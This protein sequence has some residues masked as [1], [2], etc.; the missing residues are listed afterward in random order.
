MKFV[1]ITICLMACL[2]LVG[3][4]KEQPGQ[5]KE[6]KSRLETDVNVSEPNV[7]EEPNEFRGPEFIREAREGRRPGGRFGDRGPRG[8]RGPGRFD[9]VAFVQ[10]LDQNNPNLEKL[11]KDFPDLDFTDPNAIREDPNAIGVIRDLMMSSF[12]LGVF[13]PGDV[14]DVGDV[15]EPL[16]SINLSNVEMKE[17]LQKISEWTGKVIH[18]S[19]EELM[20][21]KISIYSSKR[22]TRSK[23]LEQI[24]FALRERGY[25]HVENEKNNMIILKP[26]GQ[27][28]FEPIPVVDPNM[29][30]VWLKDKPNLIVQKIFELESYNSAQMAQIISSS[31]SEEHGSI[32]SDETSGRLMVID[33]VDNLIRLEKLIKMFDLPGVGQ[34]SE[35]QIFPV[36]HMD[37]AELVQMIVELMGEESTTGVRRRQTSSDRFRGSSFRGGFRGPFPNPTPVL[38]E[39]S[40]RLES[41]PSSTGSARESKPAT[42]QKVRSGG[43]TSITVSVAKAPRVLIP[44]LR[45]KRIIARASPSDLE[46]IR[47]LIQ[48]LD[49]ETI[50]EI[51]SPWKVIDLKYADSSEIENSVSDIVR[52]MQSMIGTT[53]LL[54]RPIPSAKKVM[55]FGSQENIKELEGVI[56]K[57]DVPPPARPHRVI[58]LKYLDPE[59]TKTRIE[60]ALQETS[61]R[62]SYSPY[63]YSGRR[64]TTYTSL[65]Q[66][67][68]TTDNRLMTITVTAPETVLESVEQMIKKWDIPIDPNAVRPKI[69]EV[70][71]SDPIGLSDLLN[72]VFGGEGQRTSGMSIMDIIFGGGRETAEKAIGPLYGQLVFQPVPNTKKIFVISKVPGAYGVIED[73]VREL[74]KAEPAE[75]PRKVVLKYADC[76]DLSE[77]LNAIFNE[78]G[79]NAR[80][81]RSEVGILEETIQVEE[82]QQQPQQEAPG[83][84]TPWW[85]GS[86]SRSRIGEEMSISNIIGRIRFVPE[87]RTKSILVLSPK[88]YIEEIIGFID[89]LDKPGKQVQIRAIVVE[90][91]RSKLDSLGPRIA[92]DPSSFGALGENSILTLTEVTQ[93]E[94]HGSSFGAGGISGSQIALN[95]R[96]NI[97]VVLDFLIK[98]VDAKVLN[99]Q[100][101]STKDNANAEFFKGKDIALRGSSTITT[102]GTVT[103]SIERNKVGMTLRVKPNITPE[104][105]VDMIMSLALS[106]LSPDLVSGEPVI[107]ETETITNM[108]VKDSQTIL[109]A[110]ILTQEDSKIKRKIAVLGDLPLIGGLFRHKNNLQSNTEL[111]VFIT[112]YVIDEKDNP[113]EV[114]PGFKS[115]LNKM[116]RIKAELAEMWLNAD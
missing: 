107:D 93:Q 34:T 49:R 105:D 18:Y 72:T 17:L 89:E 70:Y 108:I 3:C 69:I 54:I 32:I 2:F 37:P 101:L 43:A 102:G 62:T 82:D 47:C 94:S 78:P 55:I 57:L 86:G 106:Q 13:G 33:T 24:W 6:E 75:L 67:G 98:N 35:V 42:V 51:E 16:E 77:R 52:D 109:L 71:N 15:N 30:L 73:L 4:G 61:G 110:R 40:G 46:E 63:G 8:R 21:L 95:T 74:D 29:S 79:T 10:G 22:L 38:R 104:K 20:K 115:S 53:N 59:D 19:D 88:E 116:E 85:S 28:K 58:K 7:V 9:P 66:L 36:K 76:E 99:E 27:A 11:Q 23:T 100:T 25:T 114:I 68:I 96:A 103:S 14:N 12:S 112:P 5:P 84:Y 113:K 26:A 97:N 48:E 41:R 65:D 1:W 87:P 80:I 31:V 45:G 56:K 44:D 64:T 92:S 111:L 50:K 39:I 90:V 60:E 83:E 91:N 81:R